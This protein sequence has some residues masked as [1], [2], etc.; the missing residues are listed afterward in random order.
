MSAI[1]NFLFMSL[2]F[3]YKLNNNYV[4][5]IENKSRGNFEMKKLSVIKISVKI[6]LIIFGFIILVTSNNRKISIL[7]GTLLIIFPQVFNPYM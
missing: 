4:I 5:I 3:N 1:L 2:V 6:F 7:F